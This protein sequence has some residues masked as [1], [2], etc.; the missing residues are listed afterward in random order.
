VALIDV[1]Q[2]NS[3]SGDLLDSLRRERHSSLL[4]LVSRRAGSER[5]GSVTP[6]STG[7]GRDLTNPHLPRIPR[8]D[9]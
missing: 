1:G 6:A 8:R 5:C 3:F 9:R 7:H 2:P 4:L